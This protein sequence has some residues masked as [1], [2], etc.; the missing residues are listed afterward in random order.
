M[1]NVAYY[2]GVNQDDARMN[3]EKPEILT[4]IQW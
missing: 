2:P 4:Y 3:K 1:Q